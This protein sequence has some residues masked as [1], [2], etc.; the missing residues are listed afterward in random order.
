MKRDLTIYAVIGAIIFIIL[1]GIWAALGPWG[2][3]IKRG[4]EKQ[5]AQAR[6]E[7]VEGR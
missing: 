2:K 3:A 5:R 1:V 7:F 4:I 6:V